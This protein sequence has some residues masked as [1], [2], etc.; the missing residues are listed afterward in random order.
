MIR[1]VLIVTGGLGFI[2]KHFVRRCLE[3]GNY[4]TNIDNMNYAADLVVNEEFM[5]HDNYRFVQEDITELKH[6]I[7]A[8]YIVN[9]AAESHVD[10]SIV[11]NQKFC[12]T[13]ILGTQR[14]LELTRSRMSAAPYFVQ[15]STDEVYGDT[16]EG[17]HT[18]N[19]PLRPSN[20]YS[21]TKAAADMLLHGWSRTYDLDYNILR[22]SNNYG[23]HQYPE[24]LIP[25]SL[26][27]MSRG[28][29]AIMHG[30]GTYCR[31]W[32]HVEDTVNAILTVLDNGEKNTIYNISGDTELENFEVLRRIAKIANMPESDAIQTV[33]NRVGQDLRYNMDDSRI[34]ALGW[35]PT[36]DFDTSLREIAETINTER[37]L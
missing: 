8:E 19:H 14:L 11:D 20:P 36:R 2:G 18:E 30:D 10:N 5:Q 17:I 7:E 22:I 27:R 15:I 28:L 23:P 21:S 24:K 12:R 35:K 34:R 31:V 1:R 25:R 16:V 37:F 29:P 13:N 3:L 6:I 9:F 4:V 32:L 33:K 26:W